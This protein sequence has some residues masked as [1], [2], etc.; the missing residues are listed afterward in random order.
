MVERVIHHPV[1]MLQMLATALALSILV[2]WVAPV[3]AQQHD[4]ATISGH[5]VNGTAGAITPQGLTVVLDVFQAGAQPSQ[6]TAKTDTMGHFAFDG[7]LVQ[8]GATYHLTVV[9]L[10]I[11]YTVALSSQDNLSDVRVTV[12][13]ATSSLEI[14]SIR[15]NVMLVLGADAAT[16][17]LTLLETLQVA[18]KGD[19]VFIPNVAQGSVMDLLRFP[20]PAGAFDLDVQ[21]ELPEG[22]VLQVDRGVAL[23]TPVPPGE[24]SILLGY[25]LP[26]TGESLDISRVFLKGAG[27]FRLL[28]PE[29]V[30]A[31]SSRALVD[32]GV[33]AIGATNFRLLEL[34]NISSGAEVDIILDGL[35]QPSLAGRIRMA[36]P[37][38]S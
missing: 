17:T 19:R 10:G 27:S 24:H 2:G 32:R 23:T 7:A 4:T 22:Q 34:A 29:K 6:I 35:P 16:R 20:L 38:R 8:D 12:Y 30:G 31:A 9:Y 28:M 15:N 11:G 36:L 14:V 18:N 33:T 5:V 37:T 13:E 3:Y 1:R 25:K 21:A 26:Y